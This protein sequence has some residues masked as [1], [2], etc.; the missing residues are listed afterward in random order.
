MGLSGRSYCFCSRA[1]RRARP[2][3]IA[4]TT[5]NVVAIT[6]CKI[7]IV[8]FIGGRCAPLIYNAIIANVAASASS[9]KHRV[10]AFSLT[11]IGAALQLTLDG[12]DGKAT[13]DS[14]LRRSGRSRG[15]SVES[16]S[17]TAASPH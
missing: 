12:P 3:I 9:L 4:A 16:R 11:L 17:S 7:C 6:V 2:I 14:S 13:R 5:I 1:R 10:P 15:T 8:W